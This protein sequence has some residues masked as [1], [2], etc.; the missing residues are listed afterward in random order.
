MN[1]YE[2]YKKA[3]SLM[4]QEDY[5]GES[6]EDIGL[7][8]KALNSI[9]TICLDLEIKPPKSLSEEITADAVVCDA[10]VW[11]VAMLLSLGLGDTQANRLFC[12]IY[13][14]KRAYIKSKSEKIKDTLPVDDGGY[15]K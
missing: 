2:V 1:G 14:S 4:G 11:G 3:L 7:A 5:T 9:E 8:K 13:N 10:C 15:D 6:I 12:D